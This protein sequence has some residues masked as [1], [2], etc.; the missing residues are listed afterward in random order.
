M[1]HLTRK[2]ELMYILNPSIGDEALT[3]LAERI[4]ALIEA[5]GTIETGHDV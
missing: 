4:Q 3:A 2:Y 1:K 5:A